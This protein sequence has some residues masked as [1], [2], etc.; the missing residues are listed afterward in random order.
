MSQQR[1]NQRVKHLQ[2]QIFADNSRS[3]ARSVC[4]LHATR[5]FLSL[6]QESV[7]NKRDYERTRLELAEIRQENLDLK[8]ARLPANG[9]IELV[10]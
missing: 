9:K 5:L 7:K 6:R 3:Y 8:A 4:L 10:S 1:V 2:L